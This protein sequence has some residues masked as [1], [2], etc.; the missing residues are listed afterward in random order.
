MGEKGGFAHDFFRSRVALFTTAAALSLGT[1]ILLSELE[2]EGPKVPVS[3]AAST[4]ESSPASTATASPISS[5]AGEEGAVT[6]F[7]GPEGTVSQSSA[8]PT[9]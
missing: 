1:V 5:E 4:G 3:P 7:I 9:S 8:T 6:V 2:G